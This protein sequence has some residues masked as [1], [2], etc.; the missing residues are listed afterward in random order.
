MRTGGPERNKDWG[1]ETQGLPRVEACEPGRASSARGHGSRSTGPSSWAAVPGTWGG[2]LALGQSEWGPQAVCL[3]SRKDVGRQ[4]SHCAP[5]THVHTEMLHLIHRGPLCPQDELQDETSLAGHLR[6]SE[7]DPFLDLAPQPSPGT[8]CPMITNSRPPGE[9]CPPPGTP[10][11]PSPP[12]G[13]E[14]METSLG[15]HLL[16]EVH[17]DAQAG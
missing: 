9:M 16:L 7:R 1:P 15:C 10:I 12:G 6:P 13:T 14:S 3:C 17:P 5:R 8:L 2:G 11:P 4:T